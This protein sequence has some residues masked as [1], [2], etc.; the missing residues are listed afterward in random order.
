MNAET[1]RSVLRLAT[2]HG[3][4]AL[5]RL[6]GNPGLRSVGI[7]EQLAAEAAFACRKQRAAASGPGRPALSRLPA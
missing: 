2:G 1:A 6:I 5:G 3:K 7:F 4:Q